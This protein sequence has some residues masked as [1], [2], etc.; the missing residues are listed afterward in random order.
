M[1]IP[2]SGGRQRVSGGRQRG[3]RV[4]SS[5]R[6]FGGQALIRAARERLLA[7]LVASS[8]GASAVPLRP[9]VRLYSAGNGDLQ[10]GDQELDRG[11]DRA[12]YVPVGTAD[13]GN[14]RALT[15]TLPLGSRSASP[16]VIDGHW[17]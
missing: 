7:R 10:A 6:H 8:D 17:Q 3:D 14:P 16:Q 4:A 5:A 11:R 9:K 12:R 13:H 15:G 1:V 2:F